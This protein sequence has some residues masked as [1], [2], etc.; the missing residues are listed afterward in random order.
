MSSLLFETS[1]TFSL[2]FHDNFSIHQIATGLR[3]WQ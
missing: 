3:A 1:E 2:K